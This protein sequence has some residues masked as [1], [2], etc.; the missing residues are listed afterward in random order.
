MYAPVLGQKKIFLSKYSG[1]VWDVDSSPCS[2]P[3][4]GFLL[5]TCPSLVKRPGL[6]L[7]QP[8]LQI[9]S[10]VQQ[11]HHE[12]KSHIVKSQPL[13]AIP[14]SATVV[15]ASPTLTRQRSTEQCFL[16]WQLHECLCCSEKPNPTVQ[17]QTCWGALC[18]RDKG[19]RK[20]GRILRTPL[21]WV[22]HNLPGPWKG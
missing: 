19:V 3:G 11:G 2:L 15:K 10:L 4:L 14:S 18:F 5:Q 7:P 12:S 16:T 22:K 20:W 6:A 1:H 13:L 9:I 8:C 21:Q 17:F